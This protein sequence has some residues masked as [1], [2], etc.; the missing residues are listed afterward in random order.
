MGVGDGGV[1]QGSRPPP[2][3]P[4]LALA[5]AA[6]AQT[7]PVEPE[8]NVE[9]APQ[10]EIQLLSEKL[11][12]LM[13]EEAEATKAERAGGKRQERPRTGR[14]RRAAEQAFTEQSEIGAALLREAA[15]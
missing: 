3:W 7:L 13:A 12:G 15:S 2:R 6:L 10:R 14:K 9:Q 1:P 4:S 11:G 5:V 8:G